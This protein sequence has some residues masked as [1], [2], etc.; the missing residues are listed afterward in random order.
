MNFTPT[1]ILSTRISAE[2]CKESWIEDI[3]K[4]GKTPLTRP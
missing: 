1:L 4:N 3:P 2:A